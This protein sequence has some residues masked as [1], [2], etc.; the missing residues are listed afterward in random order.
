MTFTAEE[1]KAAFPDEVVTHAVTRLVKVSFTS[2]NDTVMSA[3]STSVPSGFGRRC[4]ILSELQSGTNSGYRS[5]SATRSNISAA[6]WL[7]R[8]LLENRGIDLAQLGRPRGFQPREILAG[9]VR[10]SRQRRG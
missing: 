5:T 8:R 2:L 4:R 9:V 6:L 10:R 1:A 3:T 7:T